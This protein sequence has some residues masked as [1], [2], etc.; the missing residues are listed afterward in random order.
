MDRKR[1]LPLA[2]AVKHE[3]ALLGGHSGEAV[4][5]R[6]LDEVDEFPIA[7][8][9]LIEESEPASQEPQEHTRSRSRG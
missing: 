1:L 5:D 7:E 9:H 8:E 4:A 2:R 6:A 3:Q